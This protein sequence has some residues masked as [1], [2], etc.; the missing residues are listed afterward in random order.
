MR[1]NG[2]KCIS[3]F[4]FLLT[5]APLFSITA[6]AR[7]EL[8]PIEIRLEWQKESFRYYSF[9]NLQN[10]EL[11]FKK[12]PE[13]AGSKIVRGNLLNNDEVILGFAQDREGGRIY[14]DA[15]RNLDLT[16]DDGAYIETPGEGRSAARIIK[17]LVN[18]RYLPYS[19][20]LDVFENHG[21]LIFES[22]WLAE[23]ELH[24]KRYA[25]G[26]LENLDG[27]LDSSD[28]FL[29]T[30]LRGNQK[31]VPQKW[32][33][34]HGLPSFLS[35]EDT[36]YR[37]NTGFDFSA[38]PAAVVMRLIPFSKA[39]A[40][41]ELAGI[42]IERIELRGGKENL[43]LDKPAETV[44]V[45]AGRWNIRRIKLEKN[46]S[47]NSSD[48]KIPIR[49]GKTA[50]LKAGAP[51][52]QSVAT[53]IQSNRLQIDFNLTGIGGEHYVSDLSA[54]TARFTVHKNGREIG[55]DQFEYG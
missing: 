47:C 26:L 18:G 52:T 5:A 50:A 24:G 16:D 7:E 31:I 48:L 54:G 37:V 34:E 9:L 44:P 33:P 23:Y 53:R 36:L 29:L 17:L 27:R 21:W 1:L 39:P 51:L 28:G 42:H 55:G 38:E 15:N 14:I 13:Y 25:V 19:F 2:R 20:A 4:L 43:L 45:P 40:H 8:G 22:G 11:R 30:E 6:A 32:Y 49:P 41:L 3:I 12:E 35:V 46:I 10:R